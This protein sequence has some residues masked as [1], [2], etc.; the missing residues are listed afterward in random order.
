MRHKIRVIGALPYEKVRDDCHAVKAGDQE[1]IRRHAA[2]IA[3]A[4]PD[5]SLLIPIPS[6]TGRATYTSR[7]AWAIVREARP[8]RKECFIR[9]VA[10]CTPRESLCTLKQSGRDI[11]KAKVE[12]RFRNEAFNKKELEYFRNS[13]FRQVLV[14]N[15]M[16]T[17]TTAMAMMRLIGDAVVA[18]IGDTDQ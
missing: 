2:R 8:L 15:V 9:D 12:F 18:A 6:H 10:I 7:L 14:D 13:G 4:L 16:D 3:A 17:G 5:R 11:S 1:A